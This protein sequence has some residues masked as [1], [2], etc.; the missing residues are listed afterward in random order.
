MTKGI[1]QKLIRTY[2]VIIVA[3]IV[4][5][6]FCLY[7][8]GVNLRT[9]SE[10]RYVTLPS[11]EHLKEMR[12]L[13]LDVK[14]LTNTRVYIANQKDN[15]RL[16][17]ALNV[18]YPALA[19]KLK[20]NTERWPKN[21]LT[22]YY[23]IRS[24]EEEIIDSAKKITV[25]LSNPESY[26]NDTVVDYASDLN[27]Q[28]GKQVN[29]QVRLYNELIK[30]KEN[31]LAEQQNVIGSLLD[32]LYVIV[33]LSII[34]V[35][36]VGYF[37]ARYSRKNIVDPLLKLNKS[38][39]NMAVGEVVTL[40]IEERDDEIGQMHIAVNKMIDGIVQKINFAEQ[41]G[42]ENYDAA[43]RLLSGK[44][45]LGIALLAMR[46]DLKKSN[47]TLL[48]QDKQLKDAQKLARIG[49]YFYN[50][51]TG[52]FQ[53][54][55]TLD[56]ILGIDKTQPGLTVDWRNYV[57]PEFHAIVKNKAVEAIKKRTKFTESYI[58]KRQNDGRQCWVNVIGEYN[59]NDHGRAI[60]MFGT[61]QDITENKLLD[62]ELKSSYKIAR[63]QNNK[64]LN[65]SY[66]VSHNLR[67]HAVNIHSLLDLI[68]EATSEE[69]RQELLGYL[70]TA[71]NQ[72]NDTMHHLNEVVA[73]QNARGIEIKQLPLKEY[74]AHTVGLLKTKVD[75][76]N[77]AIINNVSNEVLVNYNPIYL[78]S[79]LLNFLS[80]A[81]KYSHPE[82]IPLV[83]VNCYRKD[84]GWTL[85]IADN[86]LGID[87]ERNGDKL[88]GMYKTFHGNEDAQGIGLFMTKYQVEAMG[89]NVTVES[90]V[91]VGTTFRIYI[92]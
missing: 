54:S 40:P 89:G 85:E 74:I 32:S 71:S 81:I 83:N 15:E 70:R 46:D 7:V 87:L 28:I 52:I 66:I 79:I 86:G 1:A 9:N 42:K 78:D 68:N 75:Y 5:G 21:E 84:S 88:F 33:L 34:I 25:L 57:M 91:N 53:S 23:D 18:D 24:G 41:I 77:G 47:A 73:M 82:R 50:I 11:L 56:D 2:V 37:S 39:L 26:T 63:E 3:T 31:N 59:Y 30:T 69:E 45:K 20:T 55:P 14:K 62:I 48:E 12:A 35:I 16:E 38:I 29:T 17:R 44:D 80:N 60:S 36:A 72:L 58:L 4:S 27:A 64:L 22:L 65:F 19:G 92:K 13:M 51:E 90:T 10:M 76:K 43:F 8:L 61:I 67:M 49:N 6:S